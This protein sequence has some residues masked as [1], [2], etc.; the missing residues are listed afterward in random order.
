MTHLIPQ[1]L[2]NLTR[3]LMALVHHL[4]AW[5][6]PKIMLIHCQNFPFHLK[7]ANFLYKNLQNRC[8]YASLK[9]HFVMKSFGL[10]APKTFKNGLLTKQKLPCASLIFEWPINVHTR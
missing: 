6:C 4:G 1:A 3:G 8:R 5:T 2:K 9:S 10:L 7:P